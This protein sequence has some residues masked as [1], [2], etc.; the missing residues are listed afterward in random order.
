MKVKPCI[1]SIIPYTPDE[2][3]DGIV[4]YNLQSKEI[5]FLKA[6]TAFMHPFVPVKLRLVFEREI[7]A[8][9]NQIG[10]IYSE[11]PEE[12]LLDAWHYHTN[13]SGGHTFETFKRLCV[14]DREFANLWL[15]RPNDASNQYID[16]HTGHLNE[17]IQNDCKCFIEVEDDPEE[18][19]SN[20]VGMI[21][22]SLKR[23]APKFIN[24]KIIIHLRKP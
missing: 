20:S 22:V 15:F 19:I 8:S 13:V 9:E 6:G 3:T 7:L 14:T 11:D 16:I 2:L 21:D 18:E 1:L 10:L 5:D 12:I 23:Y 24:N 17:I 4:M